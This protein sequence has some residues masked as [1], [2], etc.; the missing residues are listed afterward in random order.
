M[1]S[2][3]DAT[4]DLTGDQARLRMDALREQST[5]TLPDEIGAEDERHSAG[6]RLVI[7]DESVIH[8]LERSR[9]GMWRDD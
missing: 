6:D 5:A 1:Q 9:R 3:D 2:A 7:A 4:M 8:P